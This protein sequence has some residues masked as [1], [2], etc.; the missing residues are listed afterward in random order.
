M[1][2]INHFYGATNVTQARD[3]TAAMVHEAGRNTN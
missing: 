3:P 1:S 2:E